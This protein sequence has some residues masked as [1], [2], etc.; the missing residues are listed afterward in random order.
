MGIRGER[1]GVGV[2]AAEGGRP[3]GRVKTI[4]SAAFMIVTRGKIVAAWGDTA[5]TFWS[6]SVRKSL[7]SALI[8][9][10]V[11][12]GR[13]PARTLAE[14]GIDEKAMPLTT[15]ERR[16]RVIDLLQARSGVY[17]PAA[18]EVD[19]MRDARP[20]RGSHPPGT[21]WYYNNWDFNVLGSIR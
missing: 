10:A 19:A 14:L 9:Q 8:G 21:F 18:A 3:R 4:G 11:G 17:I 12:E 6:H 7:L 1:R 20:K 5:R 16:A 15:E 13:S 2:V